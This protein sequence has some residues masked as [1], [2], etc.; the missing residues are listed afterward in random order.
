MRRKIDEEER[1]K[2]R[3]EKIFLETPTK[4]IGCDSI[5]SSFK[6][7]QKETLGNLKC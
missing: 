7:G 2:K 5:E 3:D 6:I 1:K 4:I